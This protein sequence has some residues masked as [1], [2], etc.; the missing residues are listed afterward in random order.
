MPT[1]VLVVFLSNPE[2][3]HP[4][5]IA[6][7]IRQLACGDSAQQLFLKRQIVASQ[8]LAL[9]DFHAATDF[10]AAEAVVP[11]MQLPQQH[12]PGK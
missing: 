5:S 1:E 7:P 8:V 11:Q 12:S 3:L 4:A 9:T 6:G 2:Q 10:Y